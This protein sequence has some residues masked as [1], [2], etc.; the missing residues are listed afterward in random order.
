[1]LYLY[2]S[3]RLELKPPL[4]FFRRLEAKLQLE[5]NQ[6]EKGQ[7]FEGYATQP[8]LQLACFP[9]FSHPLFEFSMTL[10]VHVPLHERSKFIIFSFF[11]PQVD[12]MESPPEP[13]RTSNLVSF[14][15]RRLE[16]TPQ[17]PEVEGK[18]ASETVRYHKMFP[19]T[20]SSMIS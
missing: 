1:M 12:K 3:N 10:R 11:P 2:H 18:Y 16:K 4:V 17:S 19:C 15:S 20:L 9:I 5:F 7:F 8:A 6:K 13:I 14:W